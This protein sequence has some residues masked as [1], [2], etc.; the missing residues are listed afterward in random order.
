MKFTKFLTTILYSLAILFLI[1]INDT[2]NASE[3]NEFELDLLTED[4]TTYSI[5]DMRLERVDFSGLALTKMN[6]GAVTNHVAKYGYTG[7]MPYTNSNKILSLKVNGLF[8]DLIF[9]IVK[10]QKQ[11]KY[12]YY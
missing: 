12:T 1:N 8:L 5:D 6:T 3:I 4:I 7:K 11:E 2:A 9:I 10:N